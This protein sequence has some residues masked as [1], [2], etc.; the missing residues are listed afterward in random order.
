MQARI[1]EYLKSNPHVEILVTKDEK[2][3]KLA[4][5]C[6]KFLKLHS[7]ILPDFRASFGDD[8]RPYKD[9]L[10]QINNA[11]SAFYADPSTQKILIAPFR[12]LVHPLPKASLFLQETLAFGESINLNAFKAKLLH[13]GYTFVEIVEE[14]GEASFRGDIIDFYPIN[15][16][17][18]VRISLFDDEIESIRAFACE[19]QK[20]EKE[21]LESI[22]FIPALFG[23]SAQEYEKL[24][25]D[26]ERLQS[27]S[28]I[29]DIGSLGF[30][31]LDNL[32][33][34]YLSHF[35]TL[36]VSDLSHEIED[37]FSFSQNHQKK[38]QLLSITKVP[39]PDSYK[40]LEVADISALVNYHKDK[41]ITII[42]RNEGLAKQ[43]GITADVK[44]NYLYEDFILNLLSEDE[45]IISLNKEGRKKRRKRS[46]I[47]LD[48]LKTG[49]YVVHEN[50]GIGIFKGLTNTKV[51][52]VVR[53]FV[54]IAYQGDDRLLIP[55][56]NLTLIDRYISEG[57]HLAV[58]DK[59]GKSS[60][61]K[62]KEKTR[63]KLFEIAG[64]IIEIA[65]S[66]ELTKAVNID[67][68][69]NEI[70]FF[71][72][73]A[74]FVYTDDQAKSIDEIFDDL[75][76]GKVMD[77]LLS[78][79]VGFGKTEVA[80][81]AIFACVKSGYQAAFI[82]PTTLLTSQHFKSLK[83]RFVK[84]G[85]SVAKLDRFTTAKEK[86]QTLK[87]LKEG[88][89]DVCIGTHALFGVVFNNL[90]LL[91]LDEEHKFGVKQ[92]E[93]LKA[94]K[95]NLHVLSMSATPIPRSLNMALSSIKQYSQLLTPP[96]ERE[97]VRT[98]VK[99]FNEKL[100][101]EIVL[102]EMRRGGQIF[103]VHNRIASIEEKQRELKEI[104]PD[105]KI[106]VLHSKISAAV[107]EK[108]IMAFENKAY[109]ILLSTSIIESGI[110]IPNV[111]T[112]IVENADRFGMADLHQLRGRVGR[113][114]RVGYC[115][116]LVE[117]KDKITDTS[118]KRLMALESNS[119]LGSGSVLAYHDLEIR[120]GGNL[121]GEAQS[122]H[123]KNIGY[124][125]YL[126]ML[127]DALSTLL[128]EKKVQKKEVEIKLA[129][130]AYLNSDFVG[131]DRIRLELYRRLSGC[132]SANEVYEIEE[133]MIDRFG[134]LD[135]LTKSFL[136]IIVIKILAADKGVKQISSYQQ[137]ITIVYDESKKE[138][139]KAPSKDDDDII[140][141]TL[142]YLRK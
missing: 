73:D 90:T 80:M 101:K 33:E 32:A 54:E 96:S 123:I 91:I 126:K 48:D 40:D 17:Y 138:Y 53:D 140:N 119:F 84:Y 22:A 118:K 59:L 16:P 89:I 30:W 104:L 25:L 106:L 69:E 141:T 60:F 65:A 117:N 110:H 82:A 28:F 102:R 55:V 132:E 31:C 103:Y 7:Y 79:D 29:Q 8:L 85:I 68:C 66:R 19:T 21:E 45:I 51:L 114:S 109:D 124:S 108:E 35:Q 44:V 100:L 87:G 64:Q 116:F 13:W 78:G 128:N 83:E 57:G 99:E 133:E 130:S 112:I 139:L 62:M 34:D 49:D 76:S 122:G 39:E 24:A 67:A 93:K 131:E 36:F 1:Y 129:V 127:E 12:T 72:N 97:D 95:E 9:E 136:E 56:E 26:V 120:G 47:V 88:T 63:V 107:T 71:Q 77:R 18:P 98:F 41:K 81:N 27:D 6:A 50:Y 115:Y 134:K 61:I 137:N 15:A 11:L 43:S 75:K 37:F 5:D 2:E 14:R 105:A 52:G 38:E 142:A 58:V 74:G 86:A 94:L 42:A 20:S 111:N 23:L 4:S 3:A 135:L 10:L 70:S 46:N 113:S 125:L 121:I 92:K